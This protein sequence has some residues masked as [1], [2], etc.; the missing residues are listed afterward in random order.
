[1]TL[2]RST[3]PRRP[4]GNPERTPVEKDVSVVP[5]M[6]DTECGAEDTAMAEA[7]GIIGD[8]DAPTG[9]RRLA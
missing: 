8:G 7:S 3:E 9:R 6:E 4:D 1:M 5:G 2:K